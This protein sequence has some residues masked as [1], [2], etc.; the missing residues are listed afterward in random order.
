MQLIG[1]A[2]GIALGR[3]LDTTDYGMIAMISVFSLVANELQ[4]SG[5]K[6][7]LNNL[8]QPE[9]SDYN[10]VFWFNI[11]MGLALYALLFLSAPFIAHYYHTPQL[12]PLCRY[13]FLSLIFSS[14]GTAQS[15]YLAKHIM[16]KQV[17]KA[18][19]TSTIVSS[20]TGV[21]MAWK[22]Y[23]YWSLATQTNFYVLLNTLLYWHYS[24]WRPTFQIDFGPVRR[25][26]KF[27]S[28]LLFSAILADINN[29]VIIRLLA[30]VP[31][32]RLINGTPR[33]FS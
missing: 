14:F 1:M 18:N 32:I 5:F 3:L 6:A 26:F 11:G 2:V 16:A 25:M 27:S 13:A 28:K 21:F 7:A 22:G 23:A 15:A 31:T 19:L 9:H 20:L 8:K 33:P 30:Q 24:H 12:V 4:N 17:A 29:N 10:S